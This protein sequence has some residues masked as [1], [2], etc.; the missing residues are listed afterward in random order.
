MTGACSETRRRCKLA[1]GGHRYCLSLVRP[2][3]AGDVSNH[4]AAGAGVV[5]VSEFAAAA[6]MR[7]KVEDILEGRRAARP[8]RKALASTWR[9]RPAE[10]SLTR[11]G[12]R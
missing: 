6:E 4:L 9:A 11:P 5:G 2:N 1:V 8:R 10:R 12:G 7:A 3:G